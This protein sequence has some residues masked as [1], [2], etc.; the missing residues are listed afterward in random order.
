MPKVM[1][2]M[3][4]KLVRQLPGVVTFAYNLFLGT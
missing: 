3:M 4:G 2:V 1:W